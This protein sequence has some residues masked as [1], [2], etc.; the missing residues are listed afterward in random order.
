MFGNKRREFNAR[1][2]L[3]F[4]GFGFTLDDAGVFNTLSA[5]DIAWERKYNDYESALF[6]AYIVYGGMLKN[7][8]IRANDTLKK[9]LFIQKEW[10]SK[11]VLQPTLLKDWT[12]KVIDW[13]KKYLSENDKSDELKESSPSQSRASEIYE[14]DFEFSGNFP[15]FA[16][17]DF[18]S[19]FYIP[20]NNKIYFFGACPMVAQKVVS[21]ELPISYQLVMAV[22]TEDDVPLLFVTLEKNLLGQL[23]LGV[24]HRNGDLENLGPG[25]RY[26]T[27]DSFESVALD[28]ISD[29]LAFNLDDIIQG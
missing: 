26:K 3:L 27:I 19:S 8:D 18:Y 23:T 21:H 5:L 2:S 7:Q 17:A 13:Q 12:A 20:E 25:D 24:L 1:I 22:F 14:R 28:I 29:R 4:P 11:N 9:I 10:L 6:C 16:N 15:D